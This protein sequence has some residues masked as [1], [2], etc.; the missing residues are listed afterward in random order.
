MIK[1]L[2]KKKKRINLTVY[3]GTDRRKVLEIKAACLE[4][5]PKIANIWEGSLKMAKSYAISFFSPFSFNPTNLFYWKNKT[6]CKK[7]GKQISWQRSK[8]SHNNRP[9]NFSKPFDLATAALAIQDQGY[10]LPFPWYN[11]ASHNKSISY[12]KNEEQMS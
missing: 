5:D 6:E 11:V 4:G 1:T 2:W 7:F 9:V 10:W 3:I 8:R 12:M